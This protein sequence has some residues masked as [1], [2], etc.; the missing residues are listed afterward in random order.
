MG[1]PD[2]A[3][4]VDVAECYKDLRVD[5]IRLA[6]LLS[7][8]RE[9]AEDVVQTVFLGAQR[10]WDLIENHRAYLGRAVVLRVKDM[11]RRAFHRRPLATDSRSVT[12]IP[13]VDE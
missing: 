4:P 6:L 10:R 9:T 2:A 5:L 11:Q 7:G 13:E 12:G 3:V 8:S 1:K